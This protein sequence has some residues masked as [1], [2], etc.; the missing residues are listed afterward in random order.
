MLYWTLKN[1]ALGPALNLAYRPT[2]HGLHHVPRNGP[3]IIA[4][5]HSSFF[6]S[7]A[8]PMIVPRQLRYPAKAE[9]FNQ[10]GVKGRAMATFFRAVGQIPTDR[11]GGRKSLA[12]LSEAEQVLKDGD[13]LGIYP[14]GTRSP[15]GRLYRGRTGA[16]RLALSTGSPIIPVGLEG[17]TEI[18]PI[19]ASLPKVR[20]FTA[21]F[22]EP[23]DVVE[24]LRALHAGES[25]EALDEMIRHPRR[26][27]LRAATDEVMRRI[28]AITGQEY[29]D[30]YSSVVKARRAVQGA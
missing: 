11:S 25:E 24:H 7:I 27:D 26:D 30:E 28:Q 20:T 19:E 22:G 17:M 21:T 4:A 12:A 10:P 15:D 9:Y 5:N 13:L 8:L 6:D 1:V 29:V 3:A 18:Q 23:L 14:E 2:V 16:V